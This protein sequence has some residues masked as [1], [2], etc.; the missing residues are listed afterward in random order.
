MHGA[1]MD[2]GAESGLWVARRVVKSLDRD[3]EISMSNSPRQAVIA[4]NITITSQGSVKLQWK[5]LNG[6][7]TFHEEFNIFESDYFDVIL[8]MRFLDEHDVVK[9]NIEGLLPLYEIGIETP[10]RS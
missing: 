1:T 5:L 7:R 6:N 3:E 2:T 4:N 8:G 10:G 9:F